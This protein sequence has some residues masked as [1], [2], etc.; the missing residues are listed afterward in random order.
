MGLFVYLLGGGNMPAK[1]KAYKPE[2]QFQD[3]MSELNQYAMGRKA[4]DT[5]AML[6]STQLGNAHTGGRPFGK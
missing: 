1:G 5:A 2:D 4:A 3:S 6:R